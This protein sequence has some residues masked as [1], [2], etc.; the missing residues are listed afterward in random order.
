MLQTSARLRRPLVTIHTTGDPVVPLWHEALYRRRLDWRSRLLNTAFTIDRYGHC[1]F[2]D[3]EVLAAF[4]VLVLE[5]SGQNLLVSRSALPQP[6][7]Q[8]EF[9]ELA[10]RHGARPTLSP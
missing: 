6:R 2:T 5:V 10:R 3:A 1:T 7:A 4:A 9:L 8:A